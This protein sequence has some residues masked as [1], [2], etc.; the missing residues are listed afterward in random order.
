LTTQGYTA[1]A[2]LVTVR[3]DVLT[4]RA[5]IAERLGELFST[6]GKNAKQKPLDI[7]IRFIRADVAL[8]HVRIE[9]SGLAAPNGQLLPP[10]QEL[11]LRVFLKDGGAWRV[12]AFQNTRVTASS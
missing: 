7:R 4:G 12:A 1:D 5:E 6:S 2:D 8:A 9:L 10:H 11:N 3:G